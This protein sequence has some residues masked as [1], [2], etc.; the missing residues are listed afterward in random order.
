MK[1][2]GV[3]RVRTE[4]VPEGNEEIVFRY[5]EMTEEK[6]RILNYL[7]RTQSTLIGKKD[8]N[9]VV[10]TPE[11]IIYLE[12]VDGVTYIYTKD[13]VY[14]SGLSLAAAEAEFESQGYFRCS[15]SMV[16]N[17]YHIKRLKSE[18]GNRI[19]AEMGNGEHVIISRRYAKEL[20][21]I[22]KGGIR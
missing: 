17:I 7:N 22:L 5:H 12:S 15:K 20:R 6:E 4:K 11:E 10:L 18:A 16:L 1:G 14:S 8:G 9:Q 21:Q 19:D 13:E 2:L 3:M